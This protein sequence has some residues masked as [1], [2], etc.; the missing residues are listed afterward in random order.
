MNFPAGVIFI[1]TGNDGNIPTG[2]ERVTSLNG[3]YP[4][5]TANATNPNTT[6]GA[7]TH[8]HTGTTHSHTMN[9]HNHTVYCS[10]AY[11]SYRGTSDDS[12]NCINRNHTHG[13]STSG[14]VINGGLSSVSCTYSAISNDPPYYTVLFITPTTGVDEFPQNAI[15]LYS[16]TD[17]K[18]GHY[19]CNGSNS[20]PNLVDKY[21]KGDSGTA[22]GDTGGSVTNV[23]SLTHTHTSASHYHSYSIPA[24]L[25]GGR[26]SKEPAT[27]EILKG[28][29]HSGNLNASTPGISSTAPILTTQ[30]TVEPAYKKLLTVQ[31]QNTGSGS[32]RVGMIGMW[33]GH[34]EDIPASYLL[35][36]GTNGT[37][38]MRGKHLK[39]TGTSTLIGG[40]GGSNTHTHAS[41]DHTHT[42][43]GTHTH[44]QT[45]THTA[46]R[47]RDGSVA[48][49]WVDSLVN[50]QVY[51]DVTT[52]AVT[53]TYA[54]AYTSGNEQN[55][56]P[57]YRTVAFIEFFSLN[58]NKS[59]SIT[60]TTTPHVTEVHSIEVSENITITETTDQNIRNGWSIHIWKERVSVEDEPQMPGEKGLGNQFEDV[61]VT[62]N[63]Y[64]KLSDEGDE[65]YKPYFKVGE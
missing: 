44:T 33:L 45:L 58:S 65:S 56:E 60:V 49:E 28:H 55:N 59:E 21:L 22:A 63:V 46:G 40:T 32:Y 51:H 17:S 53:A 15:Y 18:T 42:A 30:E 4:K 47:E 41:Q 14:G 9:S 39:S 5:G 29:A 52:S 54:S 36:D 50:G 64:I 19:V 6:G 8:T 13:N 62:D 11:G 25:T 2:W 16:N 37:Q 12:E 26:K 34:L 38:D 24:S 57:S 1:W 3:L 23:H 61:H 27:K 20:T 31:N 35:C 48:Y 7:A 10:A 43:S